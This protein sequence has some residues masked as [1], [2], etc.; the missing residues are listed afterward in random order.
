MAVACS[1]VDNPAK[2]LKDPCSHSEAVLRLRA[3]TDQL[4]V[5][6]N[7]SCVSRNKDCCRGLISLREKGESKHAE[8]MIQFELQ[9]E[10]AVACGPV[11]NP[12]WCLEDPCTH[13]AGGVG[14]LGYGNRVAALSGICQG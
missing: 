7:R 11:D 13:E 9:E 8:S 4:S 2:R 1:P 5:S 10:V 12:A 6:F 14:D 3:N